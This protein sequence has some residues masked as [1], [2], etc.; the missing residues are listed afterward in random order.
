MEKKGKSDEAQIVYTKRLKMSKLKELDK[1]LLNA[2]N[3]DY[4][5]VKSEMDSM[6]KQIYVNEFRQEARIKGFE[7]AKNYT[8]KQS[9]TE[10]AM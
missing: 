2:T 4:A 9:M 3:A 8:K 6:K 1:K 5:K 10:F 7:N